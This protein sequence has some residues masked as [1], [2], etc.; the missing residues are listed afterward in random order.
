MKTELKKWKRLSSSKVF[1][2]KYFTIFEDLVLLPDK[3]KY[4][5]Y[6]TNRHDKAV[7][8][9]AQDASG[10]FLVI[11][12]YRYPVDKV[13]YEPIGGGV[14]SNETPAEAAQRE[15]HEEGGYTAKQFTL[16]GSFYSN[17]SRTGAIFYAYLAQGLQ[18][19]QPEP[20]REEYLE[21]AFVPEASLVRMIREG[22]IMEPFLMM[23][24]FLYTLK[25]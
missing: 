12:E 1:Q 13:I 14:E 23:A 20:E 17:P 7:V 18:S 19:G 25:K 21:Y 3:R 15:L 11:R 10:R 9:L 22:E 24:Y 2:N 16:L 6:Y 8:V 5:Y 4:K